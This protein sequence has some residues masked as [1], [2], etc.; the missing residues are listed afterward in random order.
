MTLFERQQG[1]PNTVS[2]ALLAGLYRSAVNMKAVREVPEGVCSKC[3]GTGAGEPCAD[4]GE[5]YSRGSQFPIK[6]C[7]SCGGT[8]MVEARVE[9]NA[10]GR[11]LMFPTAAAAYEN[12]RRRSLPGFTPAPTFAGPQTE[13]LLS[14]MGA[15][16]AHS[17]RV[18]AVDSAAPVP[19]DAKSSL[20]R[21]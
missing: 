4:M 15:L 14:L 5:A 2:N 6:V 12:K 19:A 1:G 7:K 16:G 10:L 11:L 9:A 13:E 21:R 18:S 8:G 3:G 20:P 17:A